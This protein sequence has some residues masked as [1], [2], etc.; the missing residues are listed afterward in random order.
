[1]HTPLRIKRRRPGERST[2]TPKD[3]VEAVRMLSRIQND[4]QIAGV[5]NRAQLRTAYGNY[6][7]RAIV[8]S[9]RFNHGIEC[10]DPKRQAAEG[11]LNLSQAARLAGVT[12]RTLRLAI[13]RGDVSAERPI[14]SGPWVLN[15]QALQSEVATRCL[16][17]ALGKSYP[18]VPNS[19]QTLL[20]LSTT[21][22]K[23]A[24]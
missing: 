19:S 2:Q 5:L 3:I 17:K 1:V 15:K 8:T 23:G 12:N 20:D 18:T 10:H 13:D 9:L 24:L 7:T 6:W 14:P 11:W 21:Y 16:E 22:P 4:E